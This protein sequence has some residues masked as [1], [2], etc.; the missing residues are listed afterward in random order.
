MPGTDRVH[1]VSSQ[2]NSNVFLVSALHGALKYWPAL[3]VALIT[4][5]TTLWVFCTQLNPRDAG[6]A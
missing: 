2:N 5:M 6:G 1:A 3:S 4:I